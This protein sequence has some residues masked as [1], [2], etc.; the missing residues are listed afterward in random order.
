MDESINQSLNQSINQ[1][2]NVF[3][4]PFS[5]SLV[6]HTRQLKEDSIGKLKQNA[7]RYG[8]REGSPVEVQ[9]VGQKVLWVGQVSLGKFFNQS[10]T[11]SDRVRG[12]ECI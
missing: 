11:S 7:E 9:W 3:L 1:S 12:G 8:V 4:F 10:L 5:A 2:I 6:L